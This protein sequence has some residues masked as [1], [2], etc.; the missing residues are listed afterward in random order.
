MHTS[1]G[2]CDGISV[3]Q[4]QWKN[5]TANFIFSLG[6]CQI[7][8]KPGMGVMCTEK[9]GCQHKYCRIKTRLAFL[10][11]HLVCLTELFWFLL[12]SV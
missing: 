4:Q 9:A 6:F 1:L 5:E 10:Y 2:D 8:S 7:V 12:L 3:S 11:G